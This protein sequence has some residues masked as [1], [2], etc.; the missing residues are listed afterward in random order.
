M[1][2]FDDRLKIMVLALLVG[3]VARGFAVELPASKIKDYDLETLKKIMQS[4][5]FLA[6]DETAPGYSKPATVGMLI[7]APFERVWEVVTDY[8][9][10]SELIPS[11]AELKIREQD[12]NSVTTYYKIIAV[13]VGPI[14]IG[15]DYTTKQTRYKAEKKIVVT[16]IEGKVK[17]I[18]GWW[19][20]IPLKNGKETLA[21]Y[22]ASADYRD[23][24]PGANF[25]L[26][27]Q[28]ELA[29]MAS[30]GANYALLKAVKERAESPAKD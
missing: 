14:T 6:I 28:P 18:Y 7:K 13:E 15:S 3:F 20:F 29:T 21:F 22:T 26:S 11:I 8:E 24:A 19:E 16:W 10:C 30:L 17:D 2:K 12:A 1:N 27:R 9:H 4:G 23:S 5:P 25:L